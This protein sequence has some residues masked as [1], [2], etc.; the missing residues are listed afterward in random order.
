MTDRNNLT[1]WLL[2]EA[3]LEHEGLAED[4]LVEGKTEA[5]VDKTPME[6]RLKARRWL[7]QR[8]KQY[9]QVPQ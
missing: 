9:M 8:A 3:Y 5:I 2:S 1:A 6:D 7:S 4:A